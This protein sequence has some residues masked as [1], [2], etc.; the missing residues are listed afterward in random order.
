M[1][2]GRKSRERPVMVT[3]LHRINQSAEWSWSDLSP[4]CSSSTL[5]EL[6]SRRSNDHACYAPFK[7]LT[8]C[9][10]C[11]F[12][13]AV[14][15]TLL[16][17]RFWELD[18]LRNKKKVSAISFFSETIGSIVMEFFDYSIYRGFNTQKS[19]K[20]KFEFPFRFFM[21]SVMLRDALN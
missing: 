11:I 10:L 12:H 13:D 9:A 21:P 8:T 2:A 6:P 16:K 7:S 4:W 17:W 18:R 1:N 3:V 15:A 5:S 14:C 20:W 19:L